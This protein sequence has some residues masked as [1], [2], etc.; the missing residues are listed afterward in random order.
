[1]EGCMQRG[2]AEEMEQR[3][4][5]EHD[6]IAR[7]GRRIRRRAAR[8]VLGPEE[9]LCER[10]RIARIVFHLGYFRGAFGGVKGRRWTG[11]QLTARGKHPGVP[12]AHAPQE[13][14]A[15]PDH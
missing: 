10:M 3:G 5:V 7:N 11:T 14:L 4:V 12:V 6:L 9:E 13:R 15:T 2:H 8:W 1:H